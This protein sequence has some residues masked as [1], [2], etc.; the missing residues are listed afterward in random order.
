MLC[1]DDDDDG[2]NRGYGDGVELLSLFTVFNALST[3]MPVADSHIHQYVLHLMRDA[4]I[5]AYN[6]NATHCAI[7][8]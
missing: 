3:S 7:A 4:L 5:N 8:I 6:A 2:D 1:D